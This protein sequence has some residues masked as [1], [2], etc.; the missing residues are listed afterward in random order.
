MPCFYAAT[1]ALQRIGK[2]PA[3]YDRFWVNAIA[4]SATKRR[5][6]AE[7]ETIEFAIAQSKR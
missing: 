7:T 6:G 4:P 5:I 3:T 2:R 1:A